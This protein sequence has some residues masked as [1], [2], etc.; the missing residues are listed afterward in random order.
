MPGGGGGRQFQRKGDE[1]GQVLK[2]T[3]RAGAGSSY[4][5]LRLEGLTR[6][7]RELGCFFGIVPPGQP[8][9]DASW[10]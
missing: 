6:T 4:I 8:W 9:T 2:G 10:S 1:A 3:V 7:E 5:G